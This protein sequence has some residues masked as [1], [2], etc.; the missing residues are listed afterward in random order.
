MVDRDDFIE[1]KW[2]NVADSWKRAFDKVDSRIFSN[3]GKISFALKLKSGKK[4]LCLHFEILTESKDGKLRKIKY[5]FA[6]KFS[7]LGT[8]YNYDSIMHY[9]AWAGSKNGLS[10]IVPRKRHMSERIG[11]RKGLSR[12]DIAR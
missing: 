10:T 2:E 12:G 6:M 5:F 7:S 8:P 1:I 9:P 3:F 11:Q 4:F